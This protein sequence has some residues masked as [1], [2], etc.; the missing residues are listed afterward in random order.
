MD[1]LLVLKAVILGIVEGFTEF[2][3]ISSTG[4]LIVIEDLLR[5]RIPTREVFLIAIQAGAI[6]AVCWE[7]RARL[8]ALLAGLTHSSR[9]QRL[10]VNIVV[11]FLPAA[12]A[13]VLFKKTIATVLFNH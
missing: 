5:F 4:H 11:A 9:E 8:I 2:L 3:P 6:L 7:Y 10:A 12:V 13:G 1:L